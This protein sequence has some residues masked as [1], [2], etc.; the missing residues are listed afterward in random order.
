MDTFD[1]ETRSRIMAKV[2]SKN[3]GLEERFI[4]ILRAAKIK[5]FA[6]HAD[7]LLGK[8]DVVFRK[9]NV[10]VFIDSCFWHGCPDHLRRPSSNTTYWQSKI[11]RNVKRDRRTRSAL[12]RQGWSVI[13]IWEHEM[14]KPAN[15]IRRIT[16][17]LEKRSK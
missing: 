17:A 15:A 4:S 13:R 7:E 16:R 11:D 9:S 1:P 12:R 10:A 3:T 5:S 8:P 14:R 2:R 6:R